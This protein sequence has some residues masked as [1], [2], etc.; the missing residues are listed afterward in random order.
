MSCDRACGGVVVTRILLVLLRAYQFA[1][2]PL[3]GN[4][5]RFAPTCSQYALEAIERFG[6]GRGVLLA[7][8]RLLRCHPWH[9]GG[10]DPVPSAPLSASH[11]CCAC[12]ACAARAHSAQPL[13]AADAANRIANL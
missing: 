8:G 1:L 10:W 2:S 9:A 12:E 5:C 4:Q 6:P 3:L 11:G 7:L 13:P